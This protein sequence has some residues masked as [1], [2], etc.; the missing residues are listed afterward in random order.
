MLLISPLLCR[1][2]SNA[3]NLDHCI[4]TFCI[5]INTLCMS[6]SSADSLWICNWALITFSCDADCLILFTFTFNGSPL[7][8]CCLLFVFFSSEGYNDKLQANPPH[9]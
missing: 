2:R 8:E 7:F 9:F 6:Y 3:P 5:Y 1:E 4:K